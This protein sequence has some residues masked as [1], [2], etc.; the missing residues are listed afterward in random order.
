MT[1][2]N[3]E[4]EQRP[5]ARSGGRDEDDRDQAPPAG[6]SVY[7]ESGYPEENGPGHGTEERGDGGKTALDAGE[8]ADDHAGAAKKSGSR[9]Q[10]EQQ[11]YRQAGYGKNPK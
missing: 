8:S 2:K 10:D 6:G 11:A 7:E 4:R 9:Q 1:A 3:N 5:S